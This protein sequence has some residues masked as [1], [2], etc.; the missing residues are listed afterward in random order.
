MHFVGPWE[1]LI[2]GGLLCFGALVVGIVV[3]AVFLA[4]RRSTAKC[5]SCGA[6]L[7]GPSEFCPHCGAPQQP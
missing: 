7:S 5:P 3:L 1:L 6:S 2:V 4:T